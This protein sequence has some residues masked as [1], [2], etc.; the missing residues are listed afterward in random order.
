MKRV[1]KIGGTFI[2]QVPNIAWIPYRVVIRQTTITGG[3]YIGADWEHLHWFTNKTLRELLLKNGL[4][5][6]QRPAVASSQGSAS[7]GRQL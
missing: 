4:K 7:Y 5:S 3:F 2:V 1:L 6:K